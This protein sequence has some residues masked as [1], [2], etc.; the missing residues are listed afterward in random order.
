MHDISAEQCEME[1]KTITRRL[2]VMD[3]TRD[4]IIAICVTITLIVWS[5]SFQVGKDTIDECKDAC[6]ASGSVMAEASFSKCVC[7]KPSTGQ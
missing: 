4:I 5:F 7:T 6:T 1:L 3:S 2:K